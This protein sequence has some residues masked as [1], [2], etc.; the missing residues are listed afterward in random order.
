MEFISKRSRYVVNPLE[1]EDAIAEK[2]RKKGKEV[3]ELNRGDPPVYFKTPEYIIEAYVSALK[4][5]KTHYVAS[6]GV[7]ELRNAV[8]KRY[9][10][11]YNIGVDEDSIIVTQGVSEAIQFINAAMINPGE[12]A[13]LFKPYY[14]IY[15]PYLLNYGGIPLFEKYSER[16]KWNIDTDSLEKTIKKEA[17]KRPKY[18][19]ITN[20]N[21]PTGTVLDRKVLKEIVEL[22]NE[23][24][25][26]LISD[27][28]YDEI[29]FNGAKFT[30]IGE[31]A[32][33]MPHMI[34]NGASKD[35]DATGFRI[36]FAII[37]ENDKKSRQIKHAILQYAQARLSANAPA[38]YAVAEAMNNVKEH[39][40]SIRAMVK[41]I[42]SRVNFATKLVNESSY[43]TAIEPNSAF[44]LFPRINKDILK[45]KDDREF[46]KRLLIEQQVQLA[47][48]SG[49]GEEGY[50][51][52]V[53]LAEKEI[54]SL[55]INKINEFCK[56]HS[57]KR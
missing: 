17:S 47:R 50:V 25:I 36:G 46:V 40:A 11:M 1:E 57:I 19:L 37:P 2:L 52:I 41:E 18:M 15:I 23:Y 48:G 32:K 4:E 16:L 3:I 35:F 8:A 45:I 49:F 27:E 6:A 31:L 21:N 26:F 56:Q 55:A 38:Q 43:L 22:A 33:G 5:S 39:N 28:I 20:P 29:V 12:K 7:Y 30:S 24:D 54:L 53:A 10:R 14:P 13:I 51:R 9:K 42:E 34:L 44:Y